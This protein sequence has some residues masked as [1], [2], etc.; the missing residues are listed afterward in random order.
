MLRM[1]GGDAIEARILIPPRSC[2][3]HFDLSPSDAVRLA[4]ARLMLRHDFQAYLDRK[5]T[6]QNPDLEIEVVST[7]G[8]VTLPE[9]YLRGMAALKDLLCERFPEL[10]ATF[11]K[12]HAGAGGGSRKNRTGRTPIKPAKPVCRAPGCLA[13]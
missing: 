4:G 1:V 12:N 8:Q 13:R 5:L 3:G 7:G 9:A 2:P 11:E 6:A 10:D